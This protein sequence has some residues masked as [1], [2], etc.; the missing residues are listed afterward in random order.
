MP[1]D[2]LAAV[3]LALKSIAEETEGLGARGTLIAFNIS[4][5]RSIFERRGLREKLRAPAANT[6]HRRY[7][8]MEEI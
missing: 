6:L 3:D 2:D 8:G 4:F 5:E 7:G 1:N